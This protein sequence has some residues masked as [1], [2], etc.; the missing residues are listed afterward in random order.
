MSFQ[1]PELWRTKFLEPLMRRSQTSVVAL[2]SYAAEKGVKDQLSRDF[3][4]VRFST[5]Q[6]YL[7][8]PDSCTAP[9]RNPFDDRVGAARRMHATTTVAE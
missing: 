3:R 4:V 9:K 5:L 1:V 2:K 6:Q 7:P 8:E